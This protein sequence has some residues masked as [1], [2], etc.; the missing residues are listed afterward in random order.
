MRMRPDIHVSYLECSH[1][2]ISKSRRNGLNYFRV[3]VQGL[4]LSSS[5]CCLRCTLCHLSL[6]WWFVSDYVLRTMT[7]T[8]IPMCLRLGILAQ[9]W[10]VYAR[11]NAIQ[12]QVVVSAVSHNFWDYCQL[13]V[14]RDCDVC[15]AARITYSLIATLSGFII[16]GVYR[17]C[18]D[19]IASHSTWKPILC[20]RCTR[21]V[22]VSVFFYESIIKHKYQKCVRGRLFIRRNVSS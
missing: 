17:R 22:Q 10:H 13:I 11:G 4:H 14:C 16:V 12:T 3:L 20:F 21:T 8:A 7:S 19:V 1:S 9:H 15:D 6:D 2:L 18:G 5:C